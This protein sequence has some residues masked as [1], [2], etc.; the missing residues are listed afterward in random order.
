MTGQNSPHKESWTI[1]CLLNHIICTVWV[2]VQPHVCMHHVSLGVGAIY[3]PSA[4][5]GA[6]TPVF[7]LQDVEQC[8]LDKT[9][10]QDMQTYSVFRS[11]ANPTHHL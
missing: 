11:E 2:Y 4:F 3:S 10:E 8:E 6:L 9:T 1:N 7:C 5:S